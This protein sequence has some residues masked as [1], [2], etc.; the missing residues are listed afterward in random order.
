MKSKILNAASILIMLL[1]SHSSLHSKGVQPKISI[2]PASSAMRIEATTELSEDAPPWEELNSYL[3]KA[4][5]SLHQI[6]TVN[7]ICAILIYPSDKQIQAIKTKYGDS[8]AETIFDDGGKRQ[9]Y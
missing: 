1:G 8:D 7:G 2:R 4:I 5:P 3:T 6:Q 9:N